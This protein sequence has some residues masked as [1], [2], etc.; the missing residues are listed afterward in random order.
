[1]AVE[2]LDAVRIAHLIFFA[3]GLGSG[4]FFD[5]Q[6]LRCAKEELS[7]RQIAQF[8]ALHQFVFFAVGGLW[9]SGFVLLYVRT[10]LDVAQFS[11]KLWSKLFV[12]TILTANAFIIGRFV[13]TKIDLAAGRRIVDLPV[14]DYFQM[15]M[16]TGVSV[17]SWISALTLGA[18][19]YLKTAP[20]EVLGLVL[21]LIYVCVI[22]GSLTVA[23][24]ARASIEARQRAKIPVL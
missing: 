2:Y 20:W 16:A 9:L 10:G 14:S 12:V 15:A 24:A 8:R 17:A 7:N 23:F 6:A 21:A 1:M 3:L 4:S 19:V 11:P 22:A 13:R 5:W 18:S